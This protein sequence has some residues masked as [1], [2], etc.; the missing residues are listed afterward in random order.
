MEKNLETVRKRTRLSKEKRKP[1]YQKFIPSI[2]DENFVLLQKKK[3]LTVDEW[4]QIWLYNYKVVT[5]KTG[6]IESYGCIYR[7]YIKPEFGTQMLD[8]ICGEEI[9]VFYNQMAWQGY[10]NAT[11]SLIHVLLG[12]MFKQ[13][14]KNE[15]IKKN[16]MDQVIL[17]KGTLQKEPKALTVKQ[18]ELLLEYAHGSELEGI[19][20][21]ALTTGMRI[22]EITGLE[23]KDIDFKNYKIYITGTLKCTRNTWSQ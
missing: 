8:E 11:L 17:P 16:P 1:A 2:P 6:T 12:S 19:I 4:Y 3:K 23:W 20:T 7:Y 9:Q 10:S 13:A 5:V 15:R 21:I 14:Y 18:Q 22:G